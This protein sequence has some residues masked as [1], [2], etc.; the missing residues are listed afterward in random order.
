[1]R[2][3]VRTDSGTRRAIKALPA[4][5]A[6]TDL[7]LRRAECLDVHMVHKDAANAPPQPEGLQ[8]RGEDGMVAARA[9]DHLQRP[10]HERV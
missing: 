2:R 7:E 1:M 6:P 5:D 8:A 4:G 10:A 9:A 3:R